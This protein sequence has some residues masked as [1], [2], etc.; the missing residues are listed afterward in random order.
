MK[1]DI[2]YA[3]DEIDLTTQLVCLS[4]GKQILITKDCSYI[5]HLYFPLT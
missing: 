4:R 2:N 3:N 1:R 5:T